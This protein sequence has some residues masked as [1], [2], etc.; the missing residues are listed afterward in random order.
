MDIGF[1]RA[2]AAA[3]SA[4]TAA[5]V[6]LA[7]AQPA[8]AATA[9]RSVGSVTRHAHKYIGQRLVLRGYLLA[10]RP[11]YVLFSDEPRGRIGRY[12]LPVM[13]PGIELMHPRTHYVIEGTFLGSG[14]KAS[15]G[16][17]DHFLL[18]KPPHRMR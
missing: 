11:G 12:D 6:L 18:S 4:L 16:N 3:G 7:L 8:P 14:L 9:P 15:N 5:V 2:V 1:K 17:P 13:G 10:K